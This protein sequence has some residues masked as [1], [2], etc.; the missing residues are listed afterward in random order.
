MIAA[1][2][3]GHGAAQVSNDARHFRGVEGLLFANRA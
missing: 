2:A 1:Q 3:C